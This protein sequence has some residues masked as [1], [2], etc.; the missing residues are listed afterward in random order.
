MEIKMNQKQ[1]S[2]AVLELAAG[3]LQAQ[4]AAFGMEMHVSFT[5]FNERPSTEDGIHIPRDTLKRFQFDTYE[6]R[7]VGRRYQENLHGDEPRRTQAHTH[8]QGDKFV[9]AAKAATS[10][11]R[12]F[13][14]L[15]ELTRGDRYADP[16]TQ[17]DKS[18]GEAEIGY[19]AIRRPSYLDPETVVGRL[20][21]DS[22]FRKHVVETKMHFPM[23]AVI[24]RDNLSYQDANDLVDALVAQPIVR[25]QP[26]MGATGLEKFPSFVESML[27]LAHTTG[28]VVEIHGSR[29]FK[30]I[31]YKVD[32]QYK[33]RLS[34]E[35]PTP[36]NWLVRDLLTVRDP[37]V[38]DA[39]TN[40][41]I[42][43]YGDVP[44]VFSREEQSISDEDLMTNIL[45][46]S[47]LV[48]QAHDGQSMVALPPELSN[49]VE[50]AHETGRMVAI[51]EDG[52][53][54]LTDSPA[55][56]THDPFPRVN[57]LVLL[58]STDINAFEKYAPYAS[59]L[60]R[61]E[62]LE[63][64]DARMNLR[65]DILKTR[66][67]A[68]QL[69]QAADDVAQRAVSAYRDTRELKLV[70][71]DAAWYD[72][73][74]GREHVFGNPQYQVIVQ[75]GMHGAQ[76]PFIL[77]LAILMAKVSGYLVE[78]T[79]P[80]DWHVTDIPNDVWQQHLDSLGR[81]EKA[82]SLFIVEDFVR[83]DDNVAQENRL[84]EGGDLFRKY[85]FDLFAKSTVTFVP[86]LRPREKQ[87]ASSLSAADASIAH[88][89]DPQHFTKAAQR[90]AVLGMG[91]TRPQ[92]W[93]SVG[94]VGGFPFPSDDMAYLVRDALLLAKN[95]GCKVEIIPPNFYLT[96]YGVSPNFHFRRDP[97]REYVGDY[98][99]F[100]GDP[101][102][103]VEER[104][105]MARD[106]LRILST[107]VEFSKSSDGGRESMYMAMLARD[108]PSTQG[109][110][111]MLVKTGMESEAVKNPMASKLGQFLGEQIS[112]R[113]D[114]KAE[115]LSAYADSFL[116]KMLANAA[117]GC[118]NPGLTGDSNEEQDS[119]VA[120]CLSRLF[121]MYMLAMKLDIP[122][123]RQKVEE[124]LDKEKAS[125]RVAI[126]AR[127][128]IMR[129]LTRENMSIKSFAKGLK[130]LG[131]NGF[132][133]QVN[134]EH[135][136][137]GGV[138]RYE[139]TTMVDVSGPPSLEPE[140]VFPAGDE[141]PGYGDGI[142]RM[143]G[144]LA[145]PDRNPD[146]DR[147]AALR[148]CAQLVL[149]DFRTT[150]NEAK[151][152]W[153]ALFKGIVEE[154]KMDDEALKDAIRVRLAESVNLGA[155]L[156]SLTNTL[157][158]ES[159]N[160]EMLFF[161]F[162]TLVSCIGFQT[163]NIIFQGVRIADNGM[164]DL[165]I[166][167]TPLT[168]KTGKEVENTG[169][170]DVVDT[171]APDKALEPIPLPTGAATPESTILAALGHAYRAGQLVHVAGLNRFWYT[172]ITLEQR[173]QVTAQLYG[174]EEGVHRVR[175]FIEFGEDTSWIGDETKV[176][177][178]LATKVAFTDPGYPT[179][180]TFTDW[181][182]AETRDDGG[183]V[184][185]IGEPEAPIEPKIGE[186][187]LAFHEVSSDNPNGFVHVADPQR[188][189]KSIELTGVGSLWL[190]QVPQAIYEAISVALGSGKMVNLHSAEHA[191]IT[192]APIE[193]KVSG[194]RKYRYASDYISFE[195]FVTDASKT[196]LNDAT[197]R[198]MILKA[199][200]DVK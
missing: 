73:T 96:N 137:E 181:R 46:S 129:E 179:L 21:R 87:E 148:Q 38:R 147:F 98:V 124:Y 35:K 44:V 170:T 102:M 182:L 32:E 29:S 187:P 108:L 160:E 6:P 18:M 41:P 126:I 85:H 74:E 70:G 162:A 56:F 25:A 11:V 40:L 95:S 139:A 54:R 183:I 104:S 24:D 7:D 189:A 177:A 92:E 17:A 83:Y 186:R 106:V 86:S 173:K 190:S 20:D 101:K 192:S 2:M 193:S 125:D 80:S 130:I 91:E 49:A 159:H 99:F 10:E 122:A 136:V 143:A 67:A 51:S 158:G 145:F 113:R 59:C 90:G 138:M 149:G 152:V 157:F 180:E 52:K 156:E 140:S 194:R 178:L 27:A 94:L 188:S 62:N 120:G 57:Q 76:A 109:Q 105:E 195:G 43:E 84:I 146:A 128:N 3:Q 72:S 61:F 175:D 36:T 176:D 45:I 200:V 39:E 100:S 196:A 165:I 169:S 66:T 77:R 141:L 79:G 116:G 13:G 23:R 55:R 34:N 65:R 89:R 28:Y 47:K 117:A 63:N 15:S 14:A 172:D 174:S 110:G 107:P 198:E 154:L 82:P 121:G 71:R 68:T 33:L 93:R 134:A 115:I 166:V 150:I 153:G 197:L 8:P 119:N 88:G 60:V 133:I 50:I 64:P 53:L 123:L 97:S 78:F 37:N 167:L 185:K 135:L 111:E 9:Q 81:P 42:V 171:A 19:G 132:D 1:I 31:D 184:D 191:E 5:P 151:G 142:Q 163:G 69:F 12:H 26:V 199:R 131:A 144:Q 58:G 22:K 4:A 48:V 118:P 112:G 75:A 16:K 30:L 127:R 114:A 161:V 164:D 168:V 103:S 155:E